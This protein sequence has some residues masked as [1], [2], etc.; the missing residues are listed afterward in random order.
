M[1]QR[2]LR[3]RR[4]AAHGAR[5]QPPRR[6]VRTGIDSLT[7]SELRVAELAAKGLTTRQIAEALFVTP[8]TV[9]FHLRH[10]YQK[11]DVGTRAALAEVLG[12]DQ[13]RG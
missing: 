2:A 3:G 1:C 12:E 11:L 10:I 7:P 13:P 4:A 9:E 8:K 6:A 5:A